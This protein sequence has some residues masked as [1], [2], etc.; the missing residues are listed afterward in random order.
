MNGT[1]YCCILHSLGS[2]FQDKVENRLT[3]CIS[4]TVSEPFC[5]SSIQFSFNF[6]N[7][8]QNS[9]NNAKDV[10]FFQSDYF[11]QNYL[12]TFV[13]PQPRIA[14]CLSTR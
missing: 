8:D 11:L 10:C 12:G 6:P 1:K 4:Y 2:I 14:S 5:A 3:S 9:M 7:S 13:P